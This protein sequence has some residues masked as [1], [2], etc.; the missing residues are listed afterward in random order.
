[1]DGVPLKMQMT[2]P[3]KP[4]KPHRML[5][6]FQQMS[7]AMV[8]VSI[9]SA[10][11]Q[12]KKISCKAG[13]GA[14]CRQ[15]V[16]ISETEVYQIAEL[17]EAMPEP[18]RSVIKKRFADGVEHFKNNGWFDK[19]NGYFE[20]KHLTADPDNIHEALDVVMEYFYEGVACPFLED[21]AC[22]IHPDRPIACREY[23]VTSPAENCAKPTA[24]TIRA[25]GLLIKP[26]RTMRYF[27]STGRLDSAGY[28]TLIRALEL[29]E[30][31]PEDFVKKT[32]ERWMADFFSHLS[33][34][35]IPKK[36]IK[37]P[38]AKARATRPKRKR[39]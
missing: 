27:G 36:G 26:S 11:S 10:E 37:P 17:V 14:C 16:P 9:E 24:E 13:C 19:L 21:E 8:D 29:A 35:K 28:L 20:D 22:S 38:K 3:A 23:L 2:V 18:R 1:V 4:V 15:P 34:N 39:K 32:G 31:V 25:I 6:I 7:N 33:K 30:A 5:P 12:G